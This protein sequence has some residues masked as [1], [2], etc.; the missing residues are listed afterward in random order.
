MFEKIFSLLDFAVSQI[1]LAAVFITKYWRRFP[2][3]ENSARSAAVDMKNLLTPIVMPFEK[4]G[5]DNGSDRS[6]KIQNYVSKVQD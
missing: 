3:R 4:V 2:F 1:S 6:N 5:T